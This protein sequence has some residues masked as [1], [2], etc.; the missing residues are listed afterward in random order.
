MKYTIT[1]RDG[2]HQVL[3]LYQAHPWV[4]NLLERDRQRQVALP[5]YLH[6]VE[7]YL[8]GRL[9]VEEFRHQ[10]DSL[11]KSP[12]HG[13][14]G[15]KGIGFQMFFNLL[16]RHAPPE[17][18]DPALKEAIRAPS[19]TEAQERFDTF[20]S[21][22]AHWREASGQTNLHLQSV[23]FFLSFLWHVQ[24]PSTFPVSFPRTR[25]G[26]QR[27]VDEKILG[28]RE[29]A[30]SEGSAYLGLVD[31]YHQLAR[32]MDR[33]H[34]A[35]QHGHE[36]VEHV[37]SLV[38]ARR[39]YVVIVPHLP[40]WQWCHRHGLIAAHYL[41]GE[42][43]N[44][45]QA[46][47]FLAKI[48]EGDL[49]VVWVPPKQ[50]VGVG[51]VT[52]PLFDDNS[53]ENG[54][55]GWWGQRFKVDW[56]A[57]HSDMG[58]LLD[59]LPGIGS[60]GS[61]SVRVFSIR[62]VAR[63]AEALRGD[64]L[65]AL[66]DE[67][68]LKDLETMLRQNMSS[69]RA[70]TV[71]A[72]IWREFPLPEGWPE[73]PVLRLQ[74]APIMQGEVG[75]AVT[76][77]AQVADGRL[78]LPQDTP[79]PIEMRALRVRLV[80]VKE[81]DETGEEQPPTPVSNAE[82]PGQREE[83][84]PVPPLRLVP[85]ELDRGPLQLPQ[86]VLARA[87]AALNAGKHLI[88]S[89]PPGTGKTSLATV[90]ARQA[91]DQGA[92]TGAMVVTATAAWTP[93][94]TLGGYVPDRNGQ[95]AFRPGLFLQAIQDRRWLIIDEVNRADIDKAFGEFF[96]LLT[97]QPVTLP[98]VDQD[99]KTVTVVPYGSNPAPGTAVYQVPPNWRIIATMNVY[100]KSS[101]FQLS[102]AF[103]RRFALVDV[104]IPSDEEYAELL[105]TFCRE[106][107]LEP[108]GALEQLFSRDGLLELRALGPAILR[109]VVGMYTGLAQVSN[110]SPEVNLVDAL[111]AY[112][113]PQLEGLEPEQVVTARSR[114]LSA[115]RDPDA[116]RELDDRL[117]EMF[118][119]VR[120]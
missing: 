28:V 75:Q 3:R 56:L 52:T 32:E 76:L 109:D 7:A 99:G 105:E 53:F 71:P 45:P 98:F 110:A 27:L 73:G 84:M 90:L 92:C 42:Q 81:I 108:V 2:L 72:G 114:L 48:Q 49:V 65:K 39:G 112:V 13:L 80:G 86:Q 91:R 26:V 119:H 93:F 10:I 19:L 18:L 107:K 51:V 82:D 5:Q 22:V 8:A 113:L 55:Q 74:V 54:L 61:G 16:V 79:L 63:V 35:T 57:T 87:C 30:A 1:D 31:L 6:L 120:F 78:R 47:G 23:H 67:S 111:V 21:R 66:R 24:A 115:V 25:D 59:D 94:T 106:H 64:N 40:L 104:G 97:G 44:A 11:S 70:V 103:M 29:P 88:L 89:G 118:P 43:P 60:T 9:G 14:W 12:E 20:A 68:G 17:E 15:T 34:A 50:L 38:A 101:L 41:P 95:L 100:D 117:R 46:R 33:V 36:D 102:Y 37:F 69:D 85:Q 116:R 4:P 58:V 83:V 77:E 96:T 62:G